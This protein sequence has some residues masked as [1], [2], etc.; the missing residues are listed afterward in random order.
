[1]SDKINQAK[2][3]AEKG[4]KVIPLQKN[5]KWEYPTDSNKGRHV[6]TSDTEKIKSLFCKDDNIGSIM[7]SNQISLDFESPEALDTFIA[8]HDVEFLNTY[9]N[10][11]SRG[12]HLFY[13]LPFDIEFPIRNIPFLYDTRQNLLAEII[14]P[15]HAVVMAGSKVKV[16]VGN[17]YSDHYTYTE[18]N[19]NSEINFAPQWV[20]DIIEPFLKEKYEALIERVEREENIVSSSPKKRWI[21]GRLVHD[22]KELF[23][24]ILWS[25]NIVSNSVT[26]RASTV[27]EVLQ[28]VLN[29]LIEGSTDNFIMGREWGAIM[30]NMHRNSVDR[31][32]KLLT[33]LGVFIPIRAIKHKMTAYTV[34]VEGLWKLAEQLAVSETKIVPLKTDHELLRIIENPKN[35]HT[36]HNITLDKEKFSMCNS[37]STEN[38][39]DNIIGRRT[40]KN[41][42][43]QEVFYLLERIRECHGLFQV[44]QLNRN[45]LFILQALGFGD[46]TGKEIETELNL[47]HSTTSSAL[48]KL[49]DLGLISLS[50][51]IYNIAFEKLSSFYL[52]IIEIANPDINMDN[53]Y[54]QIDIMKAETEAAFDRMVHYADKK[55]QEAFAEWAKSLDCPCDL[56]F[57]KEDSPKDTPNFENK[58]SFR[59]LIGLELSLIPNYPKVALR[60]KFQHVT[61]WVAKNT[62][63]RKMITED[64]S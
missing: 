40:E 61:I 5:K 2:K 24:K 26:M 32:K 30:A 53:K 17:G 22:F 34:S 59:R 58:G 27:Q 45:S 1:M 51:K 50:G 19:V 6:A 39:I 42:N 11:T 44:R 29:T 13:K 57:D 38:N 28:V 10:T 12:I 55:S 36:F 8:E 31:A 23:D 47:S 60:M 21:A 43:A 3:L 33:E 49:K 35:V 52:K 15:N 18:I 48:K 63:W 54:Q 56:D 9:G 7:D 37:I 41:F 46:K 16:P 62:E 25:G 14:M 20:L 4:F 64:T